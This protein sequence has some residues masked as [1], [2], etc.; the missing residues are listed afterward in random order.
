MRLSRMIN[1]YATFLGLVTGGVAGFGGLSAMTVQRFDCGRSTGLESLKRIAA[2]LEVERR[3]F[4]FHFHDW[5]QATAQGL[6]G[7][8]RLSAWTQ[9]RWYTET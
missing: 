4:S 1:K 3:F 8:A 7:P 5:R 2:T 6:S 9:C